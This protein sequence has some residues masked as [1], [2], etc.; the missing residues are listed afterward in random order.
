MM[1]K[2]YMFV[3]LRHPKS[4]PCAAHGAF[5]AAQET[6]EHNV[7][8]M[9]LY[10]NS[11]ILG[12]CSIRDLEEQQKRLLD[13]GWVKMSVTDLRLCTFGMGHPTTAFWQR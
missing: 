3:G 1:E 10:D 2:L 13:Q 11:R 7:F 4:V 8:T 5:I 6:P 12:S 9:F